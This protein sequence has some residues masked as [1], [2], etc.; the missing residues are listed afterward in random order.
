MLDFCFGVPRPKEEVDRL[1]RAISDD[2]V[3]EL[4]GRAL[5]QVGVLLT[6][7]SGFWVGI[8]VER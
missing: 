5:K 2:A 4:V 6:S 7:K 8:G 3:A 1:E